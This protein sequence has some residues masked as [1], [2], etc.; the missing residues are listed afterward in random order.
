[1]C[2]HLNPAFESNVQLLS[3][4]WFDPFGGAQGSLGGRAVVHHHTVNVRM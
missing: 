4:A 3:Y 1:M 2:P